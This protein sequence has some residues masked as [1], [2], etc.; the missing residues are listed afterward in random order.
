MNDLISR[1]SQDR[2]KLKG[3]YSRFDE[4]QHPENVHSRYVKDLLRKL[5]KP[6]PPLEEQDLSGRVT[7]DI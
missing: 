3:K 7:K 1:H 2:V 4:N 5:A 6:V